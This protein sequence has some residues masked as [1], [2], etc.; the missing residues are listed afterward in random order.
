MNFHNFTEIYFYNVQENNNNTY[1]IIY[2]IASPTRY[3][4]NFLCIL[5]YTVLA[6]HVSSA[7]CTHNQEHKLYSTAVGTRD[8]WMREGVAIKR[9][10]AVWCVYR[11]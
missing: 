6:L 7:I 9:F 10:T 5:Y 8:L 11:N 3:T 1:I 2:S 4:R